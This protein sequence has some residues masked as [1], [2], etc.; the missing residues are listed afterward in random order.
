MNSTVSFTFVEHDET[1]GTRE[2]TITK[3]KEEIVLMKGISQNNTTQI[4]L[5]H[6]AYGFL[7]QQ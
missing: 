1:T 2:M 7:L 3:S 6:L 5:P 4:E